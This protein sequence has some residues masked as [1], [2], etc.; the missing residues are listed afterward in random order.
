M[1]SNFYPAV[2]ERASVEIALPDDAERVFIHSCYMDEL[3]NGIFL[4]QSKQRLLEIVDRMKQRS[5]ID[6]VILGGTELPLILTE[7]EHN[8]IP[9]LDTTRIHVKQIVTKL[10]QK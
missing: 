10:T 4:P 9:F 7:G 3:V 1:E 5:N 8:G 2:F 6:G